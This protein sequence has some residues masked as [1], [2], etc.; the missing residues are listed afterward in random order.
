MIKVDGLDQV[1]DESGCAA[2]FTVGGEIEAAEGDGDQ[3][4]AA[5]AQFAQEIAAGAVG[6]ANVAHQIFEFAHLGEFEGGGGILRGVDGVAAAFKEANE[7][8]AR[9]RVVFHEKN[10]KA[11]GER[12]EGWFGLWLERLRHFQRQTE[13]RA[14][15]V[16]WAFGRHVPPRVSASPLAMNNPGR[17]HHIAFASSRR[18]VE[19]HRKCAARVRGFDAHATIQDLDHQVRGV[20]LTVERLTSPPRGENLT[21]FLSRIQRICCNSV[22]PPAQNYLTA[23]KSRLN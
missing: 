20:N 9:I 8:G 21:A 22:E 11:G 4:G 16:A 18:L 7:D 17:G 5:L 12:L 14:M 13:D 15:A 19:K 2:E 1:L 6:E 10:I 3:G 23:Q